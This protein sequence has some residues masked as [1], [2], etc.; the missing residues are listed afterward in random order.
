MKDETIPDTTVDPPQFDVITNAPFRSRLDSVVRPPL[1]CRVRIHAWG[2][3][4]DAFRM[5]YR[6]NTLW[7]HRM[8]KGCGL[9]DARPL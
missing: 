4:S 2:K 5:D 1:R 9:I 3:W 6:P 7:Q 8:C